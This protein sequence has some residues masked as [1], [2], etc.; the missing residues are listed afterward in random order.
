MF[1]HVYLSRYNLSTKLIY[2]NYTYLTESCTS[3]GIVHENLKN[4]K[5]LKSVF[6]RTTH[7]GWNTYHIPKIHIL[8]LLK[9]TIGVISNN[10]LFKE[11]HAW[12]TTVPSQSFSEYVVKQIPSFFLLHFTFP[13]P[14]LNLLI[15]R[16]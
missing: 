1:K 3:Q 15:F 4:S 7:D 8:L 11:T 9:R 12:F 2:I 10:P 6:S 16:E 5:N 13:E 14:K